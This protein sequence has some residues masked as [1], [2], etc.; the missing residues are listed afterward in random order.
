MKLWIQWWKIVKQLRPCFSREQTFLWFALV[1]I[2]FSTRSD[3]AGVTSIVRA[4][5]LD[6]FYYDR[7]LDFFHSAGINLDLL[8]QLWV[9]IILKLNLTHKVNGRIIIIADG[10]KVSKEGRKM[11][12]VKSLHQE[13]D[14]NSK[15]EYI[16][17]HS[18][19]AITLLMTCA[20]YFFAVPMICRIHEGIVKSNRNTKTVN[21]K[22]ILMLNILQIDVPFYFVA[23][24]YYANKKIVSGLL[25]KGQHL[26]SRV[27]NN[28]VAYLP[29][30]KT[31]VVKSGRPK[32]YGD[33]VQLRDVFKQP[34]EMS[35]VII[36][37]YDD[38]PIE[39]AYRCLDL[40]WRPVGLLVRF[41][42]VM[43]PKRGNVILMSTDTSLNPIEI[44]KIY[45]LRFKIEVSFKQAINSI[46][47]HAY[48]FWMMTMT[49]I[50]R[51]S[52]DQYLH[53][54]SEEYRN[55]VE[56]K[57]NAYHTHIQIGFIAQGLLQILSMTSHQLVWKYF[58][59]WIRTIRPG[60]LPSEKIVMCSLQNTLPEFLKGS[61]TEGN[62]E[63][64]ILDKVDTSRAEGQRM[65]A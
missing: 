50:K 49:K 19:Q 25:L 3:L 12:A 37:I 10:I 31:T 6:A 65:I 2:G 38:K 17:G 40:F 62:I 58:G 28:A 57:I 36:P 39:I 54:K 7:L 8:S 26:I 46:G 9:K 16:M 41:V 64:F 4:L 14:S 24:S 56:R 33:K 63:K 45:A 48:H 53:K 22:M 18:C 21:D 30:V 52:G 55:Q 43:H 60:I 44:I 23:D 29:A 15:P 27:R 5:G 34:S 59:S 42:F 61:A 11:P 1:L 47:T 51:K 32:L 35:H 13:S 20:S